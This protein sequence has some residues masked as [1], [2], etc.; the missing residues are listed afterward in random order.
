MK[1]FNNYRSISLLIPGYKIY[2]KFLKIKL[3]K[4]Y[5]KIRDEAQNGFHKGRSCADGYFSLKLLIEKCSELNLQTHMALTDFKKASDK[6]DRNIL[7]EILQNIQ[8]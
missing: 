2:T 1:D 5:D 4:F 7:L 3:Y 8:V 6:V